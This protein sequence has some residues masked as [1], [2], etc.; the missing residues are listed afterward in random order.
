VS[1]FGVLGKYL[2]ES[3]GPHLLTEAQIIE[4]GSLTS[5]LSGKSY[6]R[7]KRIHQLLAL[8]MELEDFNS[9]QLSLEEEDLEKTESLR[10]FLSKKRDP[11]QMQHNLPEE[12]KML[13]EKYEDFTGETRQ[14]VHG[15]TAQYWIGYVDMVHLFHE[16]T[17][18]VRT[19]DIKLYICCLP[20][21]T[22][23]FVTF[24]HQNYARW[25]AVYHDNLL[26]LNETHPE[27]YREF[28][29]GC[30]SIKRTSKTFSRLPIDLTLEQTVNPDA[31][32]Q[33]S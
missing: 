6:K 29:S 5:F 9:F 8:A 19:G 32:C 23:F 12:T 21:L 3:G 22:S 7:C 24:N 16:F 25:L 14:G 11:N 15:Q 10:S 26:K 27:V 28:K 33:R 31:A 17:R 20:K 2:A 30:F 18:S 4:K 1:Y 13:I